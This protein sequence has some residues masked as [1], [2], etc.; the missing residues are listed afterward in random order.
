MVASIHRQA[1][2]CAGMLRAG[3]ASLLLLGGMAS[4]HCDWHSS[5]GVNFTQSPYKFFIDKDCT[6]LELIVRLWGSM[7][8]EGA[9]ALAAAL[10]GTAGLELKRLDLDHNQIGDIGATA[11]AGAL[12]H[13]PTLVNL[14]L[15]GNGIGDLGAKAIGTELWHTALLTHLDL[16]KNSIG[17]SGARALTAALRKAPMLTFLSL[18]RNSIGD[19]GAKALASVLRHMPGL[20]ALDVSANGLGNEGQL[21]LAAAMARIEASRG[22]VLFQ[23]ADG[24]AHDIL[25][26]ARK[27]RPA[28]PLDVVLA[29]HRDL[30]SLPMWKFLNEHCPMEEEKID[31]IVMLLA[32]LGV[33]E[34]GDFNLWSDFELERN[35]ERSGISEDIRTSMRQCV[36]SE[37]RG[38][39]LGKHAGEKDDEL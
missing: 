27:D 29:K 12:Q 39:I 23:H 2:P 38:K 13:M 26:Q 15:K 17:P 24:I 37:I 4:K 22:G 25:E 10:E 19:E 3:L 9:V 5:E 1:Q 31:G 30:A 14:D 35:L 6:T 16:D 28:P 32:A 20:M 34:L 8:A 33:Q 7:Q 36:D 18:S 11:L 21:V